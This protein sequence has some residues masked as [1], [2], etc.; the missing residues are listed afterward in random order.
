MKEFYAKKAVRNKKAATKYA[1]IQQAQ[2]NTDMKTSVVLNDSK[3]PDKQENPQKSV[4]VKKIDG[5]PGFVE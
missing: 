3:K 2:K 5:E 4:P 1:A